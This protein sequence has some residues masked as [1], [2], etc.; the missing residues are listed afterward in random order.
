MTMLWQRGFASFGKR[1][2][3]ALQKCSISAAIMRTLHSPSNV[4]FASNS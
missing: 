3:S 1:R 2:R 4:A